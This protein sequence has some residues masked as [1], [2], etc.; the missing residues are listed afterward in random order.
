MEKQLTK[1]FISIISLYI[2]TNIFHFADTT[3]IAPVIL[4]GLVLWLLNLLIRPL[5]LLIVLPINIITLGIFTVV[6]NTWMI[7]LVDKLVHGVTIP[8][9]WVAFTLAML[10]KIFNRLFKKNKKEH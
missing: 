5:L 6:V 1:L 9:F 10:I 2:I 8:S 4:F 3:G 7:M